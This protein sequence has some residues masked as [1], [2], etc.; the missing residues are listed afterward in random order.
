MFHNIKYFFKILLKEKET[1]FWTFIFPIILGSFFYLTMSNIQNANFVVP[2]NLAVISDKIDF[3]DVDKKNEEKEKS[4]LKENKKELEEFI[5]DNDYITEKE[6]LKSKI[7]NSLSKKIDKGF[8]ASDKNV[9]DFSKERY[10]KEQII[11]DIFSEMSYQ[12]KYIKLKKIEDKDI[13]D[14]K[15]KKDEIEKEYKNFRKEKDKIR[16]NKNKEEDK[17]K[18]KDIKSNEKRIFNIIYVENEEI[19]QRLLDEEIVVG[20]CRFK[21]GE[22]KLEFKKSGLYETIART[23]VSEIYEKING[24]EKALEQKADTIEEDIKKDFM[25]GKNP[26]KAEIEDRVYKEMESVVNEMADA[27]S[28]LK[29]L[30]HNSPDLVTLYYYT[31]IAMTIL[32]QSTFMIYLTENFIPNRA[33]RSA[34]VSMSTTPKAV[35][36]ISGFCVSF[37]FQLIG[38]GILIL[39]LQFVVKINVIYNLLKFLLIIIISTLFASSL[40]FFASNII[41]K[42]AEDVQPITI[43]FIMLMSMCAGMMSH[44]FKYAID[45]NIPII[46]KINPAALIVEAIYSSSNAESIGRLYKSLGSLSVIGLILF[47]IGLILVSKIRKNKI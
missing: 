22:P 19:L 15:I 6:N 30:K 27:K 28:N 39:F 36:I 11:L 3:E 43:G 5:G 21:D 45:K 9:K 37:I 17:N 8:H 31:L 24:I 29:V 26:T 18:I 44:G 33:P 40:G 35:L 32:Y 12:E 46:N 13:K 47:V 34:R 14:L 38:I 23:A 1:L 7:D 10:D 20:I 16:K 4:R 2:I 41:N 42:K 25:M